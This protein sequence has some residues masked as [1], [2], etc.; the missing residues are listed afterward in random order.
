MRKIELTTVTQKIKE[1]FI[2][3]CSNLPENVLEALKRA[4]EKEQSPLCKDVFKQIIENAQ[5]SKEKQ[6]PLCQDT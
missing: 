1:L 5:L 4:K 3:A 2:D 6:L